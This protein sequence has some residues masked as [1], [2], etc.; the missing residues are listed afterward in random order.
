MKIGLSIYF[1]AKTNT[2][3]SVKK[4]VSEAVRNLDNLKKRDK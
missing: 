3:D 2:I 4:T 1:N